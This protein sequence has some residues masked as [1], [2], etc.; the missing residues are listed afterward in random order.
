MPRA[1]STD[2][3]ERVVA[4]V[5][6]G[7]S[8]HQAAAHYRVSVSFVVLLMQAYRQSGR[9]EAKPRGGRR[10]SK[11]EPYRKFLLRRVADKHDITMPELAADL[12]AETGTVVDPS[13]L[14]KWFIRNG[15]SLK[16]NASGQRT[17]SPRRQAST[18]RMDRSSP[19]QNA[20]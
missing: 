5:K 16:K 13:S 20:A 14:S 10:H 7:H 11:L 12:A 2:L 4:Y 3:R 19:A 15:Y 6:A 1:Y 9:I 17:R 18:R 8:C